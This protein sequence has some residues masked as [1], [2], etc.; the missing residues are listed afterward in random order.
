[1]RRA[2]AVL[3]ALVIMR[4]SIMPSLMSFGRVDCRTNTVGLLDLF[5]AVQCRLRE[6]VGG[7]SHTIFISH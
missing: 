5:G 4:S 3:H 2:E 7:D 6:G 1:M